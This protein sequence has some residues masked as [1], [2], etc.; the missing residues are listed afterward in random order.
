M[1]FIICP[2]PPREGEAIKG[3]NDPLC[4]LIALTLAERGANTLRNLFKFRTEEKPTDEN[5]MRLIVPSVLGIVLC[6]VCLCG[7]T[8]AWFSGVMASGTATVQA[9]NYAIDAKVTDGTGAEV[10]G[11][12]T[13][14]L[15]A[16]GTY[17]V[18]LTV[19]G[20][21]EETAGYCRV[22]YQD[23]LYYTGSMKKGDTMTFQVSAGEGGTLT[24]LG[25]WGTYS[26]SVTLQ[27]GDT[28]TGRAAG[29]N[30]TPQS[31]DPALPADPS[32]DTT[33]ADVTTADTEK[34][35]TRIEDTSAPAEETTT[36]APEDTTG[37][38]E[39]TTEAG[40]EATQAETSAGESTIQ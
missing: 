39:E 17:T 14:A 15:K 36:R 11:K 23:T 37:T 16:G 22:T 6:M 7:T 35:D 38:P 5:I 29:I 25:L 30:Q 24:V 26:G 32:A 12:D 13:F 1:I 21:A 18:A 20:T 4:P 34:A 8:W 2:L 33:D 9:A 10:Q 3:Y 40:E 27:A 19:G 28:I 31:S